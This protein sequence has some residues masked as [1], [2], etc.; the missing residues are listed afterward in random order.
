MNRKERDIQPKEFEIVYKNRIQNQ[1]KQ[2]GKM[3]FQEINALL[4]AYEYMRYENNSKK[5]LT[6][7]EKENEKKEKKI[8]RKENEKIETEKREEEK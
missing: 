8:H 4:L 6:A 2:K 3:S 7:I 1:L 5:L